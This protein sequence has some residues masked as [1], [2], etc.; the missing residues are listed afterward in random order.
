MRTME[1]FAQWSMIE[2]PG[3]HFGKEVLFPAGKGS[4]PRMQGALSPAEGNS[5]QAAQKLDKPS[6][7]KSSPR[8]EAG[9]RGSSRSPL[10]KERRRHKHRRYTKML[11][12][13]ILRAGRILT[14]RT[15]NDLHAAQAHYKR[16]AP[17]S[18]ASLCTI[19]NA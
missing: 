5:R 13:N 12:G 2:C 1:A 8:D 17:I 14:Q 9:T 6:S 7:N 4:K 19:E 15:E 16:P 3:G 11:S 10:E 18:K